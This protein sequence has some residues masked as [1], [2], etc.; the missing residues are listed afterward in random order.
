MSDNIQAR[1]QTIVSKQLAVT[2]DQVTGSSS[3]VNDLGADEGDITELVMTLET[4][5][6][7][8][9]SDDDIETFNTVQSVINYVTEKNQS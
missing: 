1:V 8:S 7:L 9:I 5:F 2:P 4:E 3:L 6:K